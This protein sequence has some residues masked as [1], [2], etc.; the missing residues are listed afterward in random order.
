MKGL[1]VLSLFDGISCGRVALDRANIKVEK[2]IAYEVD[3]DAIKVSKDNYSDIIH[4]GDVFFGD[5]TQF[6]GF[7][8]LIGGSP[9]THW[10]TARTTGGREIKSEGIGWD[11]FKQYVRALKES[12]CKYFLYENNFSIHQNIKDEITKNLGV[13]PIMI[14]SSLVSAQGRKRMYWT[15]IPDITQPKDKGILF[16]DVIGC[17]R[18]WSEIPPWTQKVWGSKKKIDTLRV[19]DCDKSFTVTTNKTHPKNHYL[20]KDKTKITKLCSEEIETLQTLPRNYTKCLPETK[21]FKAIGNGWTV[22]V[23]SH[24]LS[25]IP[26]V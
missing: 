12:E 9:C 26:R 2:Y 10:S 3:E 20:N 18:K 21:R 19:I 25:H 14:D 7:D 6:K 4:K 13:Q 1:K 23:I 8:L 11:F 24:I 5:Y 17:D 22:D 16:K 15:N